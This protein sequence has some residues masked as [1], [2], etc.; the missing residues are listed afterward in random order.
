MERGT[1]ENV[2]DNDSFSVVWVETVVI[3]FSP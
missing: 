1:L 3:N 2:V